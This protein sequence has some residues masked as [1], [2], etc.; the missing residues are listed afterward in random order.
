MRVLFAAVLLMSVALAGCTGGGD[1]DPKA[2]SSSS[3][4]TSRSTTTSAPPASSATTSSSTTTSTAPPPA[5]KPPTGSIGAASNGTA[6][7][8]T[9]TGS[10]PDG[11]SL[12]WTLAFGD[13]NMTE[14]TSLPANAQH[15][16]SVG[17]HTANFTVTDGMASASYTLVVP[18][19]AAGLVFT[20]KQAFPSNPA[21]SATVPDVGFPGAM[22]CVGF[23]VGQNGQDCV[24]SCMG[25]LSYTVD[26]VFA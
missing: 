18:V 9:L 17:N 13:G 20:M 19:K 8:F 1:D 10:D 6:V 14:G 4:S 16:Y 15:T 23:N 21:N 7:N 3:S 24:Y 22:S 25:E 26:I 11:D 2:A 12:S 5:N